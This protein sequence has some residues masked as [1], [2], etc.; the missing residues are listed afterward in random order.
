MSGL[1]DIV[2]EAAKGLVGEAVRQMQQNQRKVDRSARG[3]VLPVEEV[4]GSRSNGDPRPYFVGKMKPFAEIPTEKYQRNPHVR[5]TSK[6]KDG[7]YTLFYDF[8]DHK[9]KFQSFVMNYETKK[10]AELADRYGLPRQFMGSFKMKK[11]EKARWMREL[12]AVLKHGMF[13]IIENQFRPDPHALVNYYSAYCCEQIAH[14]IV[15]ALGKY[16]TDSRRERIEL[17]MKFVQDIPYAV[18]YQNDPKFIYGGVVTPPQILYL[19]FGDCDS[20]SFLFAGI[21]TYL[22]HPRDIAF[23]SVPGHLLTVIRDKPDKGMVV[24]ESDGEQF[25]LAETAG[26]GRNNYGVPSTYK[27]G[28]ISLTRLKYG[29]QAAVIP[30][31]DQTQL[32]SKNYRPHML[33]AKEVD[34][35]IIKALK[36]CRSRRQRIKSIVFGANGAW[37]VLAGKSR[38]FYHDIPQ[39]ML[40][41][42]KQLQAKKIEIHDAALNRNQEFVIIYHNG[43]GFM[44]GLHKGSAETLGKA[45]NEV[46]EK[47]NQAIRDVVFTNQQKSGWLMTFGKYGNGFTCNMSKALLKKLQEPITTCA[48]AGIRSV[49]FTNSGG[50]L[51]VHG[52]NKFNVNLPKAIAERVLPILKDL[53]RKKHVVQR[54]YFTPT[55][56]FIVVYDDH[57]FVTSFGHELL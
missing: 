34:P 18:P 51:I 29:K 12:K 22:I 38:F 1:M 27:Q 17:A 13:D 10:L 4:I 33:P 8:L 32:G 31:G 37:L 2:K 35:G 47:H 56:E 20:K 43:L 44:S 46:T 40:D 39:P 53:S 19:K 14:Q 11:R 41:G 24:V 57:F 50:W 16:G 9:G 42:L 25:V 45:M 49:S 52:K 48:K 28:E 7:Q 6:E 54:V 21:L 3:E 36:Q 26:P 5:I 30:Y 15:Q 23:L 55:D